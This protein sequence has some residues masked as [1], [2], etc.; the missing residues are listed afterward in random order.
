VRKRRQLKP[1]EKLQIYKEAT[2]ARVHGNG[3]VDDV[4]RR[5]GI[6]SNDLTRITKTVEEGSIAQF[7]MN[8]SRKP[9]VVYSEE[10]MLRWEVERERLE[11][12]VI[13]QA[14]EIALIKKAGFR[15][16]GGSQREISFCGVQGIFGEGY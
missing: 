1:E 9:R 3:S 6:H 16:E 10:E 8:R 12:A 11:R 7:K 5:C 4:L 13:E 2:V 14:A 15:V